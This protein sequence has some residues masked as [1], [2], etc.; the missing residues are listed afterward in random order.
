M[1][2]NEIMRTTQPITQPRTDELAPGVCADI[3]ALMRTACLVAVLLL[4]PASAPAQPPGTQPPAGPPTPTVVADVEVIVRGD[5]A[6]TP[7]AASVITDKELRTLRP[8]TLHDALRFVPGVRT[9]DDDVLGRRAGIA[10]RGAPTR[11]SRKTLLLEDGVPINASAYLDPSAHYTPPLERLER[12]DVLKGAGHLLH[13]PLNNHG[14]V[15]FRNRRPTLT[16]ETTAEF[17]IGTLGAFR[18]HLMHRRTDGPV[19]LV[20]AYTGAD[21]RGAFDVERHRYDDLFGSIDVALGARHEVG[22]STTYFRERSH[23][24]E[25]NLTPQE[26]ARAPRVK[27]G[28]YGEDANLLAV[29]YAK[30]DVVHRV[31]TGERFSMS[32]RAF[33]TDLDRPRFAADPGDAPI[34]RLPVLEPE[35]PFLAGVSGRMVGR[36]RHY[37]TSGVDARFALSGLPG[38]GTSHVVQWGVRVERHRLDDRRRL[39]EEGQVLEPGSRGPMVRHDAYAADAVSGFAKSTLVAGAMLVTPGVRVERYTQSR[40]PLPARDA[41]PDGRPPLEDTNTLVLPSLSIL[42]APRSGTSV[43]ANL[44]RG[45]TPAF[46][47]TAAGFPLAPETGINLQAGARSSNRGISLEAAAFYNRLTDTVVQLPFTIDQQGIF[48]NA[49]DSRSYGIDAA[50][51]IDVAAGRG[52]GQVFVAA[53]YTLT[54]AHFVSGLLDGKRVP[55]VPVHTGSLTAGIEDARGWHASVT[56]DSSG[57]FFSDPANTVLFTLADE[58]G[59]V[60]GPGDVFD[61]REPVVLGRVPGR[62]LLSARAGY[63]VPGT[64]ATVWVQGRNLTDRLYIADLANGLRPGAARTVTAGVRFVF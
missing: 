60:L 7:G 27:R 30:F 41:G 12:V 52:G 40:P 3:V 24:D 54:R 23:W 51:R 21:G 34:D 56:V 4:L 42:Y 47:R 57:R 35:A 64:S 63:Q 44:A 46:A 50:G 48:I 61:V 49:E 2:E 19:G 36:D 38:P 55:E 26:F 8:F 43:F 22:L 5:A 39:G 6:G 13:G 28:R 18:R 37:R 20:L 59:F 9:L 10:V 11:R 53:V 58:D 16:P 31:R 32:S 14:I 17:G 15:N 25:S 62:T 45:Y 29:N 33:F 1:R